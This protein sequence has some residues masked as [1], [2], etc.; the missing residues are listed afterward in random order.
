[1]D[2][3]RRFAEHDYR[4]LY[5][6]PVCRIQNA[7]GKVLYQSFPDETVTSLKPPA[8]LT[9]NVV[10]ITNNYYHVTFHCHRDACI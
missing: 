10:N 4:H 3:V 1:M 7:S 5:L 6:V 9:L 2:N 8:T